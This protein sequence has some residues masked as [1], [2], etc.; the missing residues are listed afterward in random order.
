METAIEARNLVLT[1]ASRASV[2]EDLHLSI[3]Q[4]ETLGLFSF[5]STAASLLLRSFSGRYPI[6]GGEVFLGSFNARRDPGHVRTISTFVPQDPTF[7]EFF[8]VLDN[9]ILFQR[10]H[11]IRTKSASPE[12]R[13][14][15]RHFQ[16][17]DLEDR[18]PSDLTPYQRRALVMARAWSVHADYVFLDQPTFGL[19]HSEA[20][21]LWGLI[22]L[23]KTPQQ[24]LV[25]SS[26]DRWE[27][28]NYCDR[29]GLLTGGQIVKV[30]PPKEMVHQDIGNEVVEFDLSQNEFD[31]YEKR[32]RDSFDY[33]VADDCLHLYLKNDQDRQKSLELI[34]SDQVLI[35][36]ANLGDVLNKAS[37]VRGAQL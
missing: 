36:R 29:V 16:L 33:H 37:S 26:Q 20:E 5:E 35:R 28:E 34:S 23:A 6:R 1:S 13:R 17:E 3:H 27:V 4:S 7:D 18:T 15:L 11:G 14:C 21:R 30:G 12:A 10:F 25:F 2:I 22:Q 32:I 8:S 24:T 19:K 31:Y 9:L